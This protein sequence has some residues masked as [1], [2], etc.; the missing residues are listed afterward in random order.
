MAKDLPY[1]QFYVAD[2]LVDERLRMCS[3]AARG[4][5][6]DML[7]L[8][9]RAPRRGYLELKARTPLAPEKLARLCGLSLAETSALLTE[10]DD[11]GVPSVEERTSV[12]YSRRM[13]RDERKRHACSEAGKRGGGNPRLKG[14]IKGGA[15]RADKPPPKVGLNS[16]SESELGLS[17]DKP[18]PTNGASVRTRKGRRADP[19][20]EALARAEGSEPDQITDGRA[21]VIAVSLAD[22][23]R[24]TPA[25]TPDEIQARAVQY[26]QIMPRDCKVTAPALAQHWARCQPP[27]RQTE[28]K[29]VPPEPDDWVSRFLHKRRPDYA[30]VEGARPAVRRLHDGKVFRWQDLPAHVHLEFY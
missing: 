29:T 21:R 7:C 24:A 30:A 3:A 27:V 6:I 14:T 15:K 20:F 11:V 18:A 26:A 13:V 28:I 4:L 8:M 23:R 25:V 22:I 16:E 19:L 1:L 2:W 9:H 12:L 17:Y 5:W 10:L